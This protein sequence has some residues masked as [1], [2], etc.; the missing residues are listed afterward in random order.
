M[1]IDRLLLRDLGPFDQLDLHLPAGRRDD[2][3]DVHLLVGPNGTGK[4]TVL[5]ALAQVFASR[6]VG[7][8][9]RC[10]SEESI[11]VAGHHGGEHTA[12]KPHHRGSAIDLPELGVTL[13]RTEGA[14]FGSL[15][16][17][18]L[19]LAHLDGESFLARSPRFTDE[20]SL[21]FAYGAQRRIPS[22]RPPG[23]AKLVD[24]P[25]AEAPLLEKPE[26]E[27]LFVQWL[28]NLEAQQALAVRHGDESRAVALSETSARL[29]DALSQV[30]GAAVTFEVRADLLGVDVVV[31]G[32]KVPHGQLPAGLSALLAW[33]GD[34][35]MRLDRL[36]WKDDAPV[37]ARSFVLLLDEV[38]AHLHPAWQRRVLPM[39][40]TL[41]PKAQIIAATHSPFVMH[42]ASDAF[43]HRFELVE[44]RAV[45][46]G[47]E[48]GP[49]GKSY[50]AVLRDLL[51]LETEFSPEVEKR[52]AA[53]RELRTRVVAGDAD[54]ADFEVAARDLAELGEE[55]EQI[56]ALELRQLRRQQATRAVGA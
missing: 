12:W 56:V 13:S 15:Q 7:L 8:E 50:V 16:G 25:L 41:F 40:E 51:G 21:V 20:H 37:S 49:L 19:H 55:I 5:Q 23:V 31:G 35:L 28:V 24:N 11:A 6:S 29:A 27:G 26:S 46:A 4:T 22:N 54:M 1:R 42:S 9:G 39:V 2:R 36:P 47:C 34:L 32:R 14:S 3:A 53:L 44:G 10:R 48:Q 38:E 30:V 18:V 43:I 45:Y 52:F 33:V 17:G